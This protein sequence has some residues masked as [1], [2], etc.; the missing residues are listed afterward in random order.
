MDEITFLNHA[1]CSITMAYEIC[2]F[3][4][5]ITFEALQSGIERSPVVVRETDRKCGESGDCYITG[6]ILLLL[7]LLWLYAII[8]ARS[9]VCTYIHIVYNIVLNVSTYYLQ[10]NKLLRLSIPIRYNDR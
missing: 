2:L 10:Y 5:C 9:K 4:D 8:V 7:F 6:L 3:W 1:I